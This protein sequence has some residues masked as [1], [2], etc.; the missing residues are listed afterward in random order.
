MDKPIRLNRKTRDL[1]QQKLRGSM[2]SRVA[3]RA[4]ILIALDRG[5][6]IEGTASHVG[7]GSATVKRVKRDYRKGG[8]KAVEEDGV[9][10]GRPRKLRSAEEQELIAL[11]CTDPPD[12]ASRWTIR[13]LAKHFPKNISHAIVQRILKSDGLKPWREKN[14]VR[15]VHR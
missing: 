8:W 3:T 2:A 1:L 9:K 12:G 5:M 10:T 15:S 11:A 4:R 14:V 7:C 6:S 13:L